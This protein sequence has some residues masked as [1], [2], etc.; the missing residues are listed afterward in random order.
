MPQTDLPLPIREALSKY[1]LHR[2]LQNEPG[3]H[4]DKTADLVMLD[5]IINSEAQ[6]WG[7]MAIAGT[8]W[9]HR[10]PRPSPPTPRKLDIKVTENTLKDGGKYY[11]D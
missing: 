1:Y 11:L 6:G 3:F 7:Y 10:I 9:F 5:K 8:F 4:W 2:K